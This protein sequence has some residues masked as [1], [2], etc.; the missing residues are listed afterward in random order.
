MNFFKNLQSF[1]KDIDPELIQ[2]VAG[3]AQ[4]FIQKK[5]DGEEGGGGVNFASKLVNY[6]SVNR[7]IR[8]IFSSYHFLEKTVS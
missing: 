4:K 7:P 8:L 3:H 2:Q 6:S 5:D 1:A